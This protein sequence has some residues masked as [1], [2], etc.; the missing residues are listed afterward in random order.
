MKT[1]RIKLKP[2][3]VMWTMDGNW[4][5]ESTERDGL[6]FM[7]S[8]DNYHRTRNIHVYRASDG[9][10]IETRLV[11]DHEEVDSIVRRWD[12]EKWRAKAEERAL[13]DVDRAL[14]AHR[15][16]MTRLNFVRGLRVDAEESCP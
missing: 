10:H 4:R 12:L 8:N 3:P 14:D 6:R 7:L 1:G 11:D 15:K 13:V 5:P 2:P 9:T 16:A